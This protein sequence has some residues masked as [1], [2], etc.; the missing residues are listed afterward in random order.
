MNCNSTCGQCKDD[1]CDIFSGN[2]TEGCMDDYYGPLCKECESPF[3]NYYYLLSKQCRVTTI[4]LVSGLKCKTK[5]VLFNLTLF[6]TKWVDYD[7]IST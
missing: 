2:C 7:L 5:I 6:D 4:V 1:A 3:I